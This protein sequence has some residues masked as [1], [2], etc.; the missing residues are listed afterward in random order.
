MIL[1]VVVVMIIAFPPFQQTNEEYEKDFLLRHIFV[2]TF[3]NLKC[4]RW[5]GTAA[6]AN[7]VKHTCF[8]SYGLV[9]T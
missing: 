6:V 9:H 3:G 2:K 8:S 5:E 1:V 7:V 4:K